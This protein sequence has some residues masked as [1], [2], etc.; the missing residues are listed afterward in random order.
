[1]TREELEYGMCACSC[2]YQ[3]GKTYYEENT[4]IECLEDIGLLKEP[5]EDAVSRQAVN[6]L[7]NSEI[8]MYEKR[9]E[10][11]KGS[12]YYDETERI[13]EFSCRIANAEHW[14][15]KIKE[16]PSVTP[17]RKKGKWLNK[18]ASGYHFY[19]KCSECEQEFCVDAWYTQNMKFCPNCGAE[20]ES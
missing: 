17:T 11:R 12:N 2:M 15:D 20:M 6:E 14:Q 13:R 10:I 7:F 1:M 8:K 18:D 4:L 9:I 3:D 5:C 19:G 16:L